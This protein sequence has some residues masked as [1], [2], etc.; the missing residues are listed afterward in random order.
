[1]KERLQDYALVA[2]IISAIA[3]VLSLLYVG[4]QI[5][6]NTAERRLESVHAITSGY[7]EQAKIYVTNEAPRIMWHKI[8]DG[9]ELTKA[10]V[11]LFGDTLYS[12]LMLLEETYYRTQEGYLD[13]ELLDAK[14]ALVELMILLSP[15]TRSSYE[16][17]KRTGIYTPSFIAWLD[18]QLNQSELN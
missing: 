13:Q 9:E 18:D 7:R 3:V 1:M 12:H 10:E 14:M 8:L 17:S 15:Q 11:D 4:Y 5:Q 16:N 2:E 6:Q